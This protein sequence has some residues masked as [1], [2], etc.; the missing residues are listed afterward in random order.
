MKRA[1]VSLCEIRKGG[2]E[3]E[4]TLQNIGDGIS[5]GKEKPGREEKKKK[6]QRCMSNYGILLIRRSSA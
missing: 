3:K 1:D 4:D 2:K 5:A 6:K